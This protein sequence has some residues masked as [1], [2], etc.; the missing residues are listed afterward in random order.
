[1][2]RVEKNPG[3]SIFLKST[4]FP[5]FKEKQ[6]NSILNCFY[7]IMQYHHFQNYTI[8]SCYTY[9]EIQNWGKEMYP[10]LVFAI[11]G[12]FTPKWQGLASMRTANGEKPFPHNRCSFTSSLCACPASSIYRVYFFNIWFGMVQH[13][14][15]F[16]C[17]EENWLKYTDFTE[18]K[19]IT[20]TVYSNWSNYSSLFQVLQI[21]LLFVLFD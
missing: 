17:R 1:M 15:E 13:Q 4:G 2:A 14:K 20:I 9:H 16:G 12:Q 21:L 8:I 10:I 11:V 18:L 6:K 7:C 19:N 3:F 5:F